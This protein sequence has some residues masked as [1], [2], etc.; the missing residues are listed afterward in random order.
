ML[1]RHTSFSQIREERERRARERNGLSP[2]TNDVKRLQPLSCAYVADPEVKTRTELFANL[3]EGNVT[4]NVDS[5]VQIKDLS[6][7]G[8]NSHPDGVQ[9]L[10]FRE[11]GVLFP[12]HGMIDEPGQ[13]Q[14][15]ARTNLPR[16]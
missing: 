16:C 5:S 14:S 7:F 8:G 9:R 2:T 12:S 10:Q 1:G 4:A 11:D 3:K 6:K 13:L 15:Y